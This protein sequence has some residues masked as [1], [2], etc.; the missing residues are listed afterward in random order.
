[1]R[2]GVAENET[3]VDFIVSLSGRLQHGAG[4]G[5]D[6]LL[7]AGTDGSGNDAALRRSSRA[8]SGRLIAARRS[9]GPERAARAASSAGDST[10]WCR[11]DTAGR[12]FDTGFVWPTTIIIRTGVNRENRERSS[13]LFSLLPPVLILNLLFRKRLVIFPLA[14]NS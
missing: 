13:S 8:A 1:M 9:G 6:G 11:F 10:R 2:I 5:F 7:F 12:T 14:I 4:G 3:T